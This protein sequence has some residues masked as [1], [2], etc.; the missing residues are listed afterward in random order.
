[1]SLFEGS[2]PEPVELE[3]STKQISPEY[4]TNYMSQ[5]SQAGQNL[6]GTTDASGKLTAKTGEEL[7]APLSNLSSQAFLGAAGTPTYDSAG[8][9]IG[10]TGSPL[11]AYT[12]SLTKAQNTLTGVPITQEDIEKFYNPY[13]QQVINEMAKQSALNFQRNVLPS[14]KA[15]F[16]GQGA[17]GSQRYANVLGQTAADIESNLL[18]QQA[19]ARAQGYETALEAALKQAGYDVQAGQALTSLGKTEQE[20]AEEAYKTMQELGAAQ[21]AYNQSKIDAPLTRAINVSKLLQ[22]YQQPTET[23]ETSEAIPSVYQPSA[24][25]QIAGLGTLVGAAFPIDPKTGKVSGIG[26]AAF[27]FLKDIY[28]DIDWSKYVDTTADTPPI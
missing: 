18:A 4:Y 15:G 27:D 24:L 22:G 5:L 12:D 19:K 7:V 23:E 8:N 6:L 2:A 21:T 20:T 28:K 3:R 9:I 25:Q 10:Y 14:L 1:M 17:L 26:G 13:E 11:T 16:V